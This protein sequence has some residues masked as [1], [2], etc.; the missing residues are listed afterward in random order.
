MQKMTSGRPAAATLIAVMALTL[1]GCA[2]VV[3]E[4]NQPLKLETLTSDG[5]AVEG[6]ECSLR[7]DRETVS[8]R[9]GA[10]VMIRRSADDLYV[11]CKL[12]PYP[13]A[14]ARLV[15]RS[16][17]QM[18]GNALFLFGAGAY[19]DHRTGAGYNYPGWIQ[20]VFG[21]SLVFDRRDEEA[22]TPVKP[23]APFSPDET[24][25]SASGNGSESASGKGSASATETG[26]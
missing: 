17:A 9:S 22:S 26:K 13:E 3:H 8:A 25:E 21:Q 5:Q 15:S 1:G 24:S 4:R 6:A 18:M 10:E 19:V 7:N 14:T 16:N 2:S 12:D 23:Q 20:P 11:V